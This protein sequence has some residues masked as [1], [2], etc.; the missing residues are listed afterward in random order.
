VLLRGPIKLLILFGLGGLIIGLSLILFG[1]AGWGW[2]VPLLS[3]RMDAV[4]ANSP[5]LVDLSVRAS[6]ILVAFG[7]LTIFLSVLFTI[8]GYMLMLWNGPPWLLD[9]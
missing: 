1:Y 8:L 9:P 6:Y 2:L 3:R 7:G 5:R 4:K